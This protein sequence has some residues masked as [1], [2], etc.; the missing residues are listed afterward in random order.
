MEEIDTT[1]SLLRPPIPDPSESTSSPDSIGIDKT[2]SPRGSPNPGSRNASRVSDFWDFLERQG[3]R[4]RSSRRLEPVVDPIGVF[5]CPG[6]LG[7][8]PYYIPARG[9]RPR[10]RGPRGGGRRSKSTGRESLLSVGTDYREGRQRRGPGALA[11]PGACCFGLGA[12]HARRRHP[13]APTKAARGDEASST[14]IKA[15]LVASTIRSAVAAS[16]YVSASVTS[17][18]SPLLT[19]F[20]R[21]ALCLSST[22]ASG[23]AL[24]GP[25][26]PRAEMRTRDRILSD[27]RDPEI[28]ARRL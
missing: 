5:A 2:R 16:S 19:R 3:D 15:R 20:R 11:S 9:T 22:S 26:A 1:R 23:L 27:S 14:A 13:G 6:G 8:H 12:H 17:S 10:G 28:L 4:S 24:L 25:L 7:L 21:T 18:M